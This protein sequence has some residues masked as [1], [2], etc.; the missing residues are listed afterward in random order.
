[1]DVILNDG[2]V[3]EYDDFYLWVKELESDA[4]AKLIRKDEDE[5]AVSVTSAKV[6]IIIDHSEFGSEDEYNDA[7]DDLNSGD[8]DACAEFV[9]DEGIFYVGVEC[10]DDETDVESFEIGGGVYYC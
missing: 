10:E 3:T 7:V 9:T 5:E 2:I 4:D 8:F 1:M 6:K